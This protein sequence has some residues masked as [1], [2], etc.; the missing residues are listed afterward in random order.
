[1]RS[2]VRALKFC[3]KITK[4]EKRKKMNKM[5]NLYM[6]VCS[7]NASAVEKILSRKHDLFIIPK[8]VIFSKVYK[9]L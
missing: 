3:I 6:F 5:Y 1:M 7:T 8:P 2:Y 4:V 9:R